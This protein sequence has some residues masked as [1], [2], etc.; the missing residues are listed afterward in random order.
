MDHHLKQF[1]VHEKGNL[2]P[3]DGELVSLVAIRESNNPA[4]WGGHAIN[5]TKL[6]GAKTMEVIQKEEDPSTLED[7]KAATV[8][9]F[10][11]EL[12]HQRKVSSETFAV[13][14]QAFGRRP[15]SRVRAKQGMMAQVG[16]KNVRAELLHTI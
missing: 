13:M 14:E 1:M 11:R 10:G 3:K 2:E 7:K 16:S 9:Q 5:G 15:V 4:E 12:F 8:I 6:L